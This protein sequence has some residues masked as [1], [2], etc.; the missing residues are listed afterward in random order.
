MHQAE[1]RARLG[2]EEGEGSCRK[3]F[4]RRD[5]D[6]AVGGHSALEDQARC[7]ISSMMITRRE[8][9]IHEALRSNGRAFGGG[10]S[11]KER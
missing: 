10:E 4:A 5:N 11:S 6:E 1:K 3:G 9:C 7:I 2:P 8:G